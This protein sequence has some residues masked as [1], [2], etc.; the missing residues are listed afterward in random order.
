[1]VSKPD[2]PT[3]EMLAAARRA[4]GQYLRELVVALARRLKVL[5]IEHLEVAR[6]ARM[7]FARRR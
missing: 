4:R 6:P 2:W 1:M 5:V 7:R 3:P